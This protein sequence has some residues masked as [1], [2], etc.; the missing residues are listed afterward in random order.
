MNRKFLIV[1]SL[2]KNIFMYVTIWKILTK[3]DLSLYIS[4]SPSGGLLR[5]SRGPVN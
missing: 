5:P 2:K 4:D 3:T 1:K